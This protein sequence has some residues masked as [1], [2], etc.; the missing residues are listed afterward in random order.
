MKR[1]AHIAAKGGIDHL[2]LLNAGFA[3]EC[4]AFDDDFP[5][6]II[7]GEVFEGDL[8]IRQRGLNTV[9][10]FSFGHG[11]GMV[12]LEGGARVKR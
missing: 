8:C 5:M 2:M 12:V 1:R 10:D 6:V 3:R 4:R 9:C 7:P 11:H